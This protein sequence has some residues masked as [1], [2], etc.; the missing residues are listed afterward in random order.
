METPG[1]NL[2]STLYFIARD[3]WSIRYSYCGPMTGKPMNQG[4][5]R[6]CEK[7][8]LKPYGPKQSVLTPPRGRGTSTLPLTTRVGTWGAEASPRPENERPRWGQR[9]RVRNLGG[10]RADIRVAEYSS[11]AAVALAG[12]ESK[13]RAGARAENPSGQKTP[14]RRRGCKMGRLAQ[15][16]HPERVCVLRANGKPD[17]GARSIRG[18]G[19][20][21]LRAVAKAVPKTGQRLG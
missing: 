9:G 4:R 2:S 20:A 12:K 11:D 5:G 10:A 6:E 7:P 17:W 16:V 3:Q 1:I 21:H 14:L 8:R 15:A 13:T 18:G 19:R